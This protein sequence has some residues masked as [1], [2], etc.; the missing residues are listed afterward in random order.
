MAPARD[1]WSYS[2]ANYNPVPAPPQH[3]H[4]WKLCKIGNLVKQ[5]S[6]NFHSS[7]IIMLSAKRSDCLDENHSGGLNILTI[8]DVIIPSFWPTQPPSFTTDR[9]PPKWRAPDYRRQEAGVHQLTLGGCSLITDLYCNGSMELSYIYW[10]HIYKIIFCK[11]YIALQIINFE[12]PTSPRSSTQH[13][14]LQLQ[15]FW[16]QITE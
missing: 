5:A 6:H 4:N 10:K 14:F 12:P 2:S 11:K 15:R 13:S 7:Y 1:N 9:P 3:V 8:F 16:R